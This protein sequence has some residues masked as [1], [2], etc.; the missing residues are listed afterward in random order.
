M[1]LLLQSFA[2]TAKKLQLNCIKKHLSKTAV[3]LK[4]CIVQ[5]GDDVNVW[6]KKAVISK[7]WETDCTTASRSLMD[8]IRSLCSGLKGKSKLQM[9]VYTLRT[10]SLKLTVLQL[11]GLVCYI[12]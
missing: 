6:R 1:T 9:V 4:D 12:Y 3:K 5:L 11:T 10:P 2:L 8:R 7:S